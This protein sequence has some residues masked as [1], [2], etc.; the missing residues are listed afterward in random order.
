M[1]LISASKNSL[2]SK[3]NVSTVNMRPSKADWLHRLTH[4]C[5]MFYSSNYTSLT[6]MNYLHWDML[7]ANFLMRWQ[8]GTY[9]ITLSSR[10]ILIFLWEWPI[11]AVKS[12]INICERNKL[13]YVLRIQFFLETVKNNTR[14][15]CAV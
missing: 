14:D 13:V 10:Y 11:I 15:K 6:E 8:I 2:F 1:K 5:I 4:K 7:I 9:F 12:T 3:K